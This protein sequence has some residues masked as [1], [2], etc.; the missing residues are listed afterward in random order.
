MATAIDAIVGTAWRWH[1]AHPGGDG[2]G[3]LGWH[4]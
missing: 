3:P 2:D 1:S 4:R